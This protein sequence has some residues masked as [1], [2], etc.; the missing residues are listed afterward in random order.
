M[1]QNRGRHLAYFSRWYMN[2]EGRDDDDDDDT[3]WG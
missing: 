2:V 3:I 1:S